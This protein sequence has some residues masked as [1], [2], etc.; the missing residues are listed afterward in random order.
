[1]STTTNGQVRKSLAQQIDRL[2]AMLDGLA[3]G[4]NDAVAAV[5]KEA[6]GVAVKEAIQS[7]VREALANPELVARLATAF[8][9]ST[10]APQPAPKDAKP[11]VSWKQRWAGLYKTVTAKLDAAR[12]WCGRRLEGVRRFAAAAWKRVRALASYRKQLLIAVGVGV[13][14]AA[15]AY[16][17][18]PWLAAAFSG[19]GGFAAALAVQ[20]GQALRRLLTSASGSS[21]SG[22]L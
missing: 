19:I 3:D 7:L 8:P 20:T 12:L 14:V 6:V 18:G 17:A 10:P 2:D 9:V 5:V 15:A 11:K 1:M 22:S 4:L 21:V 13:T 16:V